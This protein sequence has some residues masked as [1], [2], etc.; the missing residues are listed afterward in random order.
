MVRYTAKRRKAE[1]ADDDVD[2]EPTCKCSGKRRK[3]SETDHNV[4]DENAEPTRKQRK[5]DETNIILGNATAEL[6]G[7]Q[8]KREVKPSIELL[9]GPVSI[10]VKVGTGDT[11]TV[12]SL[13]KNLL[14]HISPFFDAALNGPWTE[15]TSGCVELNDDDPAAFRLFLRWLFAWMLIDSETYPT[16][17]TQGSDPAMG[18]HAWVLGDKLGVPQFQDYVLAHLWYSN[19]EATNIVDVV[20]LAYENTSTGSK[21]RLWIAWELLGYMNNSGFE[22]EHWVKLVEEVDGP[23]VDIVKFT[24]N[25]RK[26]SVWS[27]FLLVSSESEYNIGG[28]EHGE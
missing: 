14:T 17:I 21:L 7:R 18:V 3:T 24:W 1:G 22:V 6:T 2:D 16:K 11:A 15:S 28:V 13:P 25:N 12:W 8:R 4:D 5:S 23:A 9:E 27:C 20:R 10:T 26:D 19:I